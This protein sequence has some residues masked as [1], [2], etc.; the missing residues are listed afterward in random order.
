MKVHSSQQTISNRSSTLHLEGFSNNQFLH[1]TFDLF[2]KK[3]GDLVRFYSF[4]HIC[5]LGVI[6]FQFI[7]VL[8]F[9]SF[10]SQTTTSAI[11]IAS[12][13]LTSFTYFVLHFY[14]QAKK[15]QQ[16]LDLRQEIYNACTLYYRDEEE[17]NNKYYSLSS[18]F[19]YLSSHL[20]SKE[21][22]F[23]SIHPKFKTLSPLMQKFSIWM[24]WKDV[25]NMRE[26]LLLSAINASVAAVKLRPTDI[27]AH[28]YLALGYVQLSHLYQS[29]AKLAPNSIHL[30]ISSEYESANMQ[31]KF[32]SSSDRAIEELNILNEFSPSDPWVHHQLAS[33]YQS[34]DIP[35]L[36]IKEIEILLDIEKRDVELLFKLGVLYFKQGLNFK[37]LKVYKEIKYL[38]ESKAE[39]L[40]AHYDSFQI[41]EFSLDNIT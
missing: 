9:F 40:I 15:P 27:E 11:A 7:A 32:H 8:L 31:S 37:G 34:K 6:F 17:K 12:L 4:F 3:L 28:A 21:A 13:F 5:F 29:P 35:D 23:F 18:S 25:F 38:N 2:L 1:S 14:F 19:S 39:D 36:E 33:I 26:L 24:T 16:F 30:W 22:T 41:H 10:F 20:L